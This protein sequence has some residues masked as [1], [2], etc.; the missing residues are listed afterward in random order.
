MSTAAICRC[1]TPRSISR[2]AAISSP[3]AS[4][5]S[6]RCRDGRLIDERRHLARLQRSLGELRIAHADAGCRARRRPARGRAPQPGARRHRLSADHPRRGAARPCLS[7]ARYAR[8]ASS[9]RRASSIVARQRA[10]WPPRA[11]RSSPCRTTAGRASTSRSIA[12]LPNVLAK[13]AAREQGAREAWF[14]DKRRPRTEGSSSN[15]WIVTPRRQGRH[16]P[17]R[18]RILRGITRTVL[19]DVIAAQGLALEERPF[20]LEEA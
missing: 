7:A 11:S 16:P 19:L 2:T 18:P 17:G 1:A 15:A 14:V 13:Q 3:T 6:A 12:L 8:R 4:T 5:R 20:T 10:R 9:S